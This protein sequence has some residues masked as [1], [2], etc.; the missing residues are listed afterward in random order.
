METKGRKPQKLTKE[1]LKIL[2]Q[3]SVSAPRELSAAEKA[4][5]KVNRIILARLIEVLQDDDEQKA[6]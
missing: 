2:Q 5:R 3:L 1:D 4:N 6:A